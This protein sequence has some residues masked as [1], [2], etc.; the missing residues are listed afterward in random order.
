MSY[1][2]ATSADLPRRVAGAASCVVRGIAN[3]PD[4]RMRTAAVITQHRRI[5][6]QESVARNRTAPYR[7]R[8]WL[9]LITVCRCNSSCV[10]ADV[11]EAPI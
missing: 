6:P 11:V 1:F 8:D 5:E 4:R 2:Y 3:L 10:R 9:D 7:C